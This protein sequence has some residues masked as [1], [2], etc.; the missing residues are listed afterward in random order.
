MKPV[1]TYFRLKLARRSFKTMFLKNKSLFQRITFGYEP[2][3]DIFDEIAYSFNDAV[4]DSNFSVLTNFGKDMER[5][6]N[7]QTRSL[8]SEKFQYGYLTL[9]EDLIMCS[10]RGAEIDVNRLQACVSAMVAIAKNINAMYP[11]PEK[12]QM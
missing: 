5:I 2:P 4:F 9:K 8:L 6:L 1:Y 7:P 11:A 10:V 3:D 12:D